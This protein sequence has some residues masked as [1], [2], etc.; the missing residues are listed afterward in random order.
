MTNFDY[1]IGCA[2]SIEVGDKETVM[3]YQWCIEQA[4][5][6]MVGGKKWTA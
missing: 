6:N 2:K 4:F 3:F 1:W 5:N